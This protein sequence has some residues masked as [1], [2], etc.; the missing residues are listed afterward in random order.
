MS[1]VRRDHRRL[2]G[3]DKAAEQGGKAPAAS[4]SSAENNY[5]ENK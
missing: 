5:I 4:P 1:P 2:Q 3:P